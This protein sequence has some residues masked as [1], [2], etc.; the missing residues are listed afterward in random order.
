LME[1]YKRQGKK[2][3]WID[4]PGSMVYTPGPDTAGGF[5]RQRIRWSSK[6]ISYT[7]P[8]LAAISALVFLT[9][10]VIGLSVMAAIIIPGLWLP[11]GLMYMIKSIP[12]ILIL[13]AMVSG[14]DKRRLLYL[15]VPAQL[16]YPFYILAAGLGGIIKGLFSLR[17]DK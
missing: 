11:V 17:Q 12:D 9:G 4:L 7:D 2:I 13:S 14:R 3:A 16:L 6:G 10:M 15:F 5:L 8:A 1:S